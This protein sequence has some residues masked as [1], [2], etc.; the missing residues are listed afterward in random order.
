MYCIN[1]NTWN[2]LLLIK[3]VNAKYFLKFIYLLCACAILMN[4]CNLIGC[5]T[6]RAKHINKIDMQENSLREKEDV[7]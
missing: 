6:N 7:E 5:R 2:L 4:F 1:S 3:R